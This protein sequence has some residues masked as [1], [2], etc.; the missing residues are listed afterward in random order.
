MWVCVRKEYQIQKQLIKV[1]SQLRNKINS[2]NGNILPI[3]CISLIVCIK[4]EDTSL[5][6]VFSMCRYITITSRALS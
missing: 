3:N 2:S 1:L 4:F 6:F 5:D